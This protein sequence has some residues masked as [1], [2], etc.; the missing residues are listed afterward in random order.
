MQQTLRWLEGL[1]QVRYQ[2]IAYDFM[3]HLL[4]DLGL[5]EQALEQIER[6][7]ALAR[8]SGIMFWRL[9]LEAHLAISRSHLGHKDVAPGL[10]D[11]LEQSRRTSERY[12][13]VRCLEASAQTALA[14]GDGDAR[15]AFADELLALAEPNGLGEMAA[16]AR[17]SRGQALVAEKA[18]AEARTELSRAAELA[19]Q[20]GRVRL[21]M[22]AEIALARLCSVQ[23]RRDA[24]QRH[25]DQARA[26]AQAIEA[27][28]GSSG[29]QARLAHG[30]NP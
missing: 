14:E 18:Y 6:G 30:V 27:S 24:A 17:L 22:D 5:D 12:L 23:R 10:A 3:S 13:M 29:L 7:L 9:A 26:I 2:F 20:L 25:A 8:G 15:R 19:A 28:L 4:L 1:G 11:A 16:S 21:H